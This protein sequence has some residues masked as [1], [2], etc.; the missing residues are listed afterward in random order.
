[1][2]A[3][4]ISYNVRSLFVRKATTAAAA[5][6]IALVVFVFSTV[7]MLGNGIEKTLG[8]SGSPDVAIVI[9]KGSDAELSSNVGLENVALVG[10]MPQVHQRGSGVPDVVGETAV[11][12]GWAPSM[13]P[14]GLGH[15][16]AVTGGICL[17]ILT[18]VLGRSA[19]T[20]AEAEEEL[21]QRSTYFEDLVERASD[22]IG[23]ICTD[24]TIISV[25]PAV[26]R[27]LGYRAEDVEGHLIAE[28]LDPSQVDNLAPPRRA[29]SPR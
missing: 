29:P 8:R 2:A 9:S 26:E 28:F 20:A 23:V 3:I 14:A 4:P 10:A 21:R 1:M 17:T 22:I 7:N 5:I 13:I 6:G 24:G 18:D 15:A 25:S 16:I 27:V 19:Q 12:L 11:A